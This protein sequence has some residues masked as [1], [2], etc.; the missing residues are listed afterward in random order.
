MAMYERNRAEIAL[1]LREAELS[2]DHRLEQHLRE[3]QLQRSYRRVADR[4][5]LE[6]SVGWLVRAAQVAASWIA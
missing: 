3:L 4:R 5:Y 1:S 6:R 2:R